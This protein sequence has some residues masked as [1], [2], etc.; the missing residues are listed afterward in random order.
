M[1]D[2]RGVD[3]VNRAIAEH[4]QLLRHRLAAGRDEIARQRALVD[5]TRSHLD[6]VA[7]WVEETERQLQAQRDR[8]RT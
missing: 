1:D 6:E 8:A 7:L 3:G 2:Q 5:A 4:V